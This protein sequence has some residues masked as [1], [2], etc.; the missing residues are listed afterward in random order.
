MSN[1]LIQQRL[2]IQNEN[3]NIIPKKTMMIS[4]EKKKS[5]LGLGK[6]SRKA[7]NDITNKPK[8]HQHQEASTKKKNSQK[9]K[10]EFNIAEERFLHDHNKC[11]QAQQ[12]ITESMFWDI[13]L[14]GHYG[15]LPLEAHLS[16]PLKID[17]Y[18]PVE[19]E[20]SEFCDW[21]ELGPP[22]ESPLHLEST[23]C[24]PC[25]WDFEEVEF[26]LKPEIDI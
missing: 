26:F 25:A 17:H 13:V 20:M 18:T 23:P 11:I 5:K 24:S 15:N 6:G 4:E 1:Q 8:I 16:D 7:L 21:M 9:E 14:P 2:I 3:S 12:T 22:S 10:E 19:L